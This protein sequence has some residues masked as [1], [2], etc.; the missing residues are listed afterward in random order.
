MADGHRRVASLGSDMHAEI[1]YLNGGSH[2]AIV[3]NF[4]VSFRPMHHPK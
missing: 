3:D 1:Q 4:S 2:N